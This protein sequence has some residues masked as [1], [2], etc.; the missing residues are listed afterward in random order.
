M[1]SGPVPAQPVG[2]KQPKQPIKFGLY[3]LLARYGRPNQPINLFHRLDLCPD[4]PHS[5]TVARLAFPPPQTHNIYNTVIL[6][7][8]LKMIVTG[9]VDKAGFALARIW[10]IGPGEI[11]STCASRAIFA[12]GHIDKQEFK[13]L[14]VFADQAAVSINNAR[15]L[16]EV[17]PTC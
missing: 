14:R 11:R 15:A 3:R 6:E 5:F 4:K 12:R 16:E 10:L 2:T 17:L 7:S 13:W 9:V 1:F 8:V